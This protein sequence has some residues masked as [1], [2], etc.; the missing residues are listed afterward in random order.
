MKRLFPAFLIVVLCATVV[1]GQDSAA[2]S[3]I[4]GW[5]K[6]LQQKLDLIV[7]KKSLQTGNA[8]AGVRGA[9][10]DCK[11]K[12]YWKGQESEEAVTEEEMTAF[13][14]AVELVAKGDHAA[15]IKD[16][17]KFLTLFCDSPLVPDARKTLALMKAGNQE[18]KPKKPAH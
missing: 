4:S 8:V 17:E 2:D 5:L 12:L 16:L 10:E 3:G 9:R 18:A 14:S 13:K 11:V 7:P 6:S 15:A 1:A